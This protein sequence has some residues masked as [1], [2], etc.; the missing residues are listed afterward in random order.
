MSNKVNKQLL[1]GNQVAPTCDSSRRSG[2]GTL[3]REQGQLPSTSGLEIRLVFRWLN[4]TRASRAVQQY[5]NFTNRWDSQGRIQGG[6]QGTPP[7][8]LEGGGCRGGGGGAKGRC[9][10]LTKMTL[11]NMSDVP[12]ICSGT[13]RIAPRALNFQNFLGGG[14]P[15][16][17]TGSIGGIHNVVDSLSIS[18]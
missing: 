8:P 11:E 12:Q 1:P 15:N 6:C 17:P 16:P 18:L 7:P 9:M 14:P 13:L 10:I 3:A 5:M 2:F 4:A